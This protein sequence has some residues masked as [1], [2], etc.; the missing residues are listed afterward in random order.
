M[1]L[2]KPYQISTAEEY[3]FVIKCVKCALRKSKRQFLSSFQSTKRCTQLERAL[4]NVIYLLQ[5]L[6]TQCFYVTTIPETMNKGT[7]C[8]LRLTVKTRHIRFHSKGSVMRNKH[9]ALL[10][11]GPV[12]RLRDVLQHIMKCLQSICLSLSGICIKVYGVGLSQQQL[13]HN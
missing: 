12:P 13:I 10:T 4:K 6:R 9:C 1:L 5:N 2:R 11:S 3:I 8:T 7:P